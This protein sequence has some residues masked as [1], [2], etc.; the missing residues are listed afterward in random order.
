MIQ[1]KLRAPFYPCALFATQKKR[2]INRKRKI[3]IREN[4]CEKATAK[5]YFLVVGSRFY[6]FF[7]SLWLNNE[8]FIKVQGFSAI[9]IDIEV[10]AKNTNE[11]KERKKKNRRK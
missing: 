4:V 11:R 2:T 6:F 10:I 3:Q 1:Y 7:L 5:M 8:I 9:R